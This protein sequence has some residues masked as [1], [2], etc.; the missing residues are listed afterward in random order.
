MYRSSYFTIYDPTIHDPTIHDS[1]INCLSCINCHVM[2]KMM[3]EETPDQRVN[4]FNRL[5]QIGFD[6][7]S[8]K[9]KADKL[10]RNF[11]R[12]IQ[13]LLHRHNHSVCPS[14]LFKEII[15]SNREQTKYYVKRILYEVAV[16]LYHILKNSYMTPC[17]ICILS[18]SLLWRLPL[19]GAQ[20]NRCS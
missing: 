7:F 9:Q 13:I 16:L 19:A 10:K 17:I 5:I 18:C 3:C 11:F 20:R 14:F 6:S 12:R 8:L 4:R 2:K 1:C 15:Y